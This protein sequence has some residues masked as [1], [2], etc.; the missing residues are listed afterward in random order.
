MSRD[1]DKGQ[2]CYGRQLLFLR[3]IQAVV[4]HEE[5]VRR[6]CVLCCELLDAEST[7]RSVGENIHD[8]SQ[9][10]T[11]LLRRRGGVDDDS[12]ARESR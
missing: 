6:A 8:G 5:V 11:R 9:L 7:I 10:A 3:L 12:D 1:V 2:F 4:Q